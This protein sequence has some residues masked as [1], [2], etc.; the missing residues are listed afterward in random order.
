MLVT[1]PK[2]TPTRKAT[3]HAGVPLAN[4]WKLVS[5]HNDSDG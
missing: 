1:A 3:E 4:M 5:T 2:L